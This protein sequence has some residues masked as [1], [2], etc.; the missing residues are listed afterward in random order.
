MPRHEHL[1]RLAKLL[2]HISR[3]RS[4][5]AE[6]LAAVFNVSE[7]TIRRDIA[8][9]REAGVP[10]DADDKGYHLNRDAGFFL[11]PL[12]LLTDLAPSQSPD[13]TIYVSPCRLHVPRR[14]QIILCACQPVLRFR[15]YVRRL[16]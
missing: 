14:F 9:W 7:R 3:R 2:A 10:I 15:T 13:D 16:Q 5:T 1:I 12:N 6:Q 4:Y 8:L 11:P